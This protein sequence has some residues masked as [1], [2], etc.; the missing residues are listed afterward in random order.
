MG[1]VAALEGE[2]HVDTTNRSTS[3]KS[4]PLT[5]A[6][7]MV[8]V[9]IPSGK[10]LYMACTRHISLTRLS[11]TA[12]GGLTNSCCARNVAPMPEYVTG[13]APSRLTVKSR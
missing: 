13:G 2:S 9:C 5:P 4:A 6:F 3:K 1:G 11:L 12:R 7:T 8:S 10:P